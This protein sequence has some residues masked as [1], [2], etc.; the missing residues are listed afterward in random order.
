MS[1]RRRV[2]A[3]SGRFRRP[4]RPCSRADPRIRPAGW[5][6]S[7]SART[8]SVR[9][10]CGDRDRGA[11]GADGPSG[12][13]LG[14]HCH[15]AFGPPRATADV[16]MCRPSRAARGT[17]G[18]PPARA[19]ST[20]GRPPARRAPSTA[21]GYFSSF[22]MVSA[23]GL[24]RHCWQSARRSMPQPVLGRRDRRFRTGSRRASFASAMR[25]M[26]SLR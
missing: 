5:V 26:V 6:V 25:W 19:R 18:C 24:R 22:L 14:P 2:T 23:S 20:G 15:R 21:R 4:A 17:G 10:L 16:P 9:T 11:P 3:G 13:W 8:R 7:A 1:L 12:G